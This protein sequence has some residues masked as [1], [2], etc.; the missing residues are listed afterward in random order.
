MKRE[1]FRKSLTDLYLEQKMDTMKNREVDKRNVFQEEKR[2]LIEEYRKSVLE[3]ML[4]EE[5][6]KRNY[7][8]Q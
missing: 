1:D 5:E 2:R 4:K 8:Y 6:E 7:Q 3:D